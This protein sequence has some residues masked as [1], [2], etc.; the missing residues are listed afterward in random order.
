MF[1]GALFT[2]D[3]LVEGIRDTEAWKAV[4]DA[5]LSAFKTNLTDIFKA[6]PTG[7]KPNESTTENDLIFPVLKALDWDHFLTQITAA[8]KGRS[9]V[10]DALLFKDAEAKTTA[11]S[12]AQSAKKFM[13]GLVVAENKAWQIPLDRKGKH[14]SDQ[15]LV[16]LAQSAPSTQILR[17]LTVSEVHSEGRILWG[18]LTNGRNWR[19]YYQKAKSRSEDFLDIDLP[20]ILGVEGIG[21]DLLAL[22]PEV[23]DHWLKVFYIMF[24]RASFLPDGAGEQTF[25]Q[26][27]MAEGLLWERKVAESLSGLV[28]GNVFP[29]LA[30]GL[31]ANDP[32]APNPITPQYLDEVKQA[33]L[34]L[35]YRL[36]FVLYAEDRNL[37]PVKSKRYDD[38]GMRDKVRMDIAK[39]IDD[40][41]QFSD[42]RTIYWDHLKG[43]FASINEGDASIGIPPYNGG[44]FSAS[45][46]PMLNRA[47][48]PDSILAPAIDALSRHDEKGERKWIN[49]R[50][51]R[52]QQLGSIYER[53]LEFELGFNEDGKV[54]VRPNIFARKGSGSYYTPDDLVQLVIERTVSPLIN[55]CRDHF[56]DK[57]EELKSGKGSKK[58]RLKTLQDLDPASAILNLR[59][60]DP[61]MGSGHFLVT[62]V[63][64]LSSAILEAITEAEHVVDWADDDALYASPLS[65]RIETLREHIFV[66]AEAN[67]WTVE[68]EHLDDRQLVRR[69]ILKRVVHGVDFNPMAVELAKVS[70]WLH[71]FTVGAPL[72]YLDH[73]LRCGNSLFG[74]DIR[75]VMDELSKRFKLLINPYVAQAKAASAGMKTVGN[76]SD[77]DIGE[78]KTSAAAFEQVLDDTKHLSA[79]LSLRQALRW[80]GMHDL[81]KKKLP[82]ALEAIFDGSL[83]AQAKNKATKSKQK[84]DF[85]HMV[86]AGF[87]L[88][89][90]GEQPDLTVAKTKKGSSVGVKQA[91]VLKNAA[92][93][94]GRAKELTKEQHFFH[95]QTAFPDIWDNW[96]SAEVTGGFDAIIGNPPWDRMKLQEVEWFA[97]RRPEIAHQAKAAD[98]KKMVK[99]LEKAGDPLYGDYLIAADRAESA[100][101]VARKCGHYPLLSGGDINL[102]SLFVE[103]AQKLVKPTGIVG[104]L[105]PSGIASDKGAS[106]FFKTIATKGRLSALLDFEN[107][108]VFFPD[109]HASFKFCAL[110]AGGNERKF[111]QAECAFFLHSIAEIETAAFGLQP[112]DFAAVNPN[113]GTAPIF[114]TRRDADLTTAIYAR[115]PVLVDRRKTPPKTVWPVK[116]TTMFHMTNDSDKFH[117]LSELEENGCYKVGANRWKKGEDEFEP[118]YEGKMVQAYDHRAANIVVNLENL[119]RPA[120]PESATTEQHADPAWLPNPQYWVSSND[121]DWPEDLSFAIAFKDVTAPTNVR[122]MIAAIIPSSGV[123]NTLPLLLPPLPDIPE[124]EDL[125]APWEKQVAE[126]VCAYKENSFVLVANLNAMAF[127]YIARQKVQGQ[128]LNS[129]IV[130]QLPVL[131]DAAYSH[132]VG[133]TTARDIVREEVLKLTYTA[134]DMEPFARDM[135]YEGDPFVWDEDERRHSR[136]RLDALFFILYGISREDADYILSTF[137]IVKKQDMAEHDRYLTR[138][139]IL[140]Y[141]AAFEAGYADTRVAP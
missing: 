114:R 96:E 63:D 113:T 42:K 71:T 40:K 138:D 46:T 130:E 110:I 141:M 119:N 107:K 4:D 82:F 52:V 118:V 97:E 88:H 84:M 44:L 16:D 81:T 19:I 123:G 93:I 106:A 105:V 133:K 103:R 77:V 108:K 53:L 12:E 73:H 76:L 30:A 66:Q 111:E 139:L 36:L 57:A 122:T 48:L 140:A 67:T 129:Y 21:D 136:A 72:S 62:L 55:E 18:M 26:I 80:M 5:A 60:C 1:L 135:G 61:A 100:A 115:V 86:T 54:E 41:D 137:P 24:R 49:Y 91:D 50:D 127:D 126:A 117:T 65:E 90:D 32:Q 27:A 89:D 23:Q 68:D 39:R 99:V 8:K 17:Y 59:I 85:V 74:E 104:L 78:V 25:H 10:P 14:G 43:L 22:E 101:Q 6:F 131:P 64:Y 2:K 28:F 121:I 109:V 11:N 56:R 124:D 128:H 79:V 9:D 38:Y 134:T 15:D 87:P 132:K 95:W 34:I 31:A 69:I 29:S 33:T 98:R 13:H 75:D 70:L 102:Y 125:I 37:L 35:L 3:F 112:S 20:Y 51:L 7:E 45:R 58:E 94:L 120:Q 116:Y 83:V 92:R 47:G